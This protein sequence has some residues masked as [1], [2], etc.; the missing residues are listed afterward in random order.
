[1]VKLLAPAEEDVR[2]GRTRPMRSFLR[3]L[4]STRKG[5]YRR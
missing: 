1:M 4:K 2:A 3:E 5:S